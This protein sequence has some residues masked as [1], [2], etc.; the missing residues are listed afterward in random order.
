QRRCRP[1]R[2]REWALRS[3][4]GGT[5]RPCT[6]QPSHL[7]VDPAAPRCGARHRA[8]PVGATAP[9]RGHPMAALPPTLTMAMADWHSGALMHQLRTG[10]TACGPGPSALV[11]TLY[12]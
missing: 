8:R 6:L 11:L 12:L 1:P 9:A 5:L 7:S 2:W 4:P 10:R 3:P